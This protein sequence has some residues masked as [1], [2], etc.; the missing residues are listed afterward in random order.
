M[1][2]DQNIVQ[3]IVTL[4]KGNPGAI[5][6]ATTLYETCGEG[7]LI[8]LGE[9]GIVGLDIWLFFKDC[10]GTDIVAMADALLQGRAVTMLEKCVDSSFYKP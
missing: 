5:T 2:I 7:P 1:T 8:A 10:C 9:L 3:A 6:V 4:S